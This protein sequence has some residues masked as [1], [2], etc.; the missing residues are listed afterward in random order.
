MIRT[1][2]E[3]KSKSSLCCDRFVTQRTGFEKIVDIL[4]RMP[5]MRQN[6]TI[7]SLSNLLVFFSFFWLI[8]VH[9][10]NCDTDYF[11]LTQYTSVEESVTC[12]ASRDFVVVV[13]ARVPVLTSAHFSKREECAVTH[14]VK[15][16]RQP[17]VI[18]CGKLRPLRLNQAR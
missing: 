4:L 18:A 16:Q 13:K 3:L 12:L 6:L 9:G 10:M 17:T 2:K 14:A 11:Q 15:L 8:T 7:F 5:G 1:F